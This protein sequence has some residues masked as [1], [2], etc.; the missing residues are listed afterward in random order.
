MAHKQSDL[1]HVSVLWAWLFF[2]SSS[3]RKRP[4]GQNVAS[5][6]HSMDP[7]GDIAPTA[8]YEKFMFI[9]HNGTRIA[10]TATRTFY[11]TFYDP[12]II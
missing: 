6:Y 1:A 2:P 7:S 3:R 12:R 10:E 4:R 5:W 8:Y 9:R 11:T